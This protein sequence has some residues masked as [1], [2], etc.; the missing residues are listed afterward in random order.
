MFSTRGFIVP[1]LLS[2]AVMYGLSYVWHGVAL[3]DLL[4][5]KIPLGLYLGLAALVYVIIG[6][7]ITALVHLAIQHE[8]VSLKKAFPLM[9]FALGGAS[10]F[11]VFLLVYILGMSFV[12]HGAMHAAVDAIWQILEQGLGGLMVSFGIIYDLHRQFMES[13]RAR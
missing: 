2:A 13:E 10:G 12:E 3:T 6:F 5:L 4:E 8:W 9:S 1:W 7:G 11:V